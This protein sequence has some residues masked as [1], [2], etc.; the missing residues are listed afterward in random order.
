MEHYDSI[1][2]LIDTVRQRW[3]RLRAFRATVRAALIAAAVIGATL[4][5]V[6][7]MT[8]HPGVLAAA[9]VLALAAV[10]GLCVWSLAPLRRR[11]SDAQVAR[12]IE[13]RAPELE[14]RLASAVDVASANV[15]PSPFTDLAVADAAR[16]AD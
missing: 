1:R 11:P 10:L 2:R 15:A 3:L 12:F 5:A 14:D 9:T 6:R 16:R 8:G 4:G 13:E 7:W